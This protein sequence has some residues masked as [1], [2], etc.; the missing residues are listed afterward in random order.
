MWPGQSQFFVRIAIFFIIFKAIFSTMLAGS[1][2]RRLC[3]RHFNRFSSRTISA[4][5]DSQHSFSDLDL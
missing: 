4:A 1:G 5:I 2:R 3:L